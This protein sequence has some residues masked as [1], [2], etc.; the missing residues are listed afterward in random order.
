MRTAATTPPAGL[1]AGLAGSRHFPRSDGP[2]AGRAD[3]RV[4]HG[5]ATARVAQPSS[6]FVFVPPPQKF[7]EISVRFNIMDTRIDALEHNSDIQVGMPSCVCWIAISMRRSSRLVVVSP[8]CRHVFLSHACVC[9]IDAWMVLGDMRRVS[10]AKLR[11]VQASHVIHARTGVGHASTYFH[12]CTDARAGTPAPPPAFRGRKGGKQFR[13]PPTI[14]WRSS[15]ECGSA[16][17]R[18]PCCDVRIRR[19]QSGA[20]LRSPPRASPPWA[21]SQRRTATDPGFALLWWAQVGRLQWQRAQT[22]KA[23][24]HSSSLE[25]VYSRRIIGSSHFDVRARACV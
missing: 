9:N 20:G 7:A 14:G 19:E 11:D 25:P 10:V 16:H 18:R 4:D 1:N 2:P 24:C 21:D 6:S 8:Q 5:H 13:P 3:T 15:A 12:Q 22:Q 17:I 23:R